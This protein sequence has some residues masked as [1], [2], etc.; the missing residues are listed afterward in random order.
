MGR[1]KSEGTTKAMTQ[2]VDSKA[3]DNLETVY[4]NLKAYATENGYRVPNK[5]EVLTKIIAV[6]VKNFDIPGYFNNHK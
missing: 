4:G 3:I 2:V 1:N 5:G 6:G